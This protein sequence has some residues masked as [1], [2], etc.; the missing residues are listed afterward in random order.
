MTTKI[1]Q[2][3]LDSGLAYKRP[4]GKYWIDAGYIDTHLEQYTELVQEDERTKFCTFLMKLHKQ[5][6]H[7]HNHFH[8]AAVNFWESKHE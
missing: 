8:V 4:D 2:F 1:E 7:Q 3:A 6:K 5:H